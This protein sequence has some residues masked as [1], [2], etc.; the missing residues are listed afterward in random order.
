MTN[1]PEIT[2]V[3]AD[4]PNCASMLIGTILQWHSHGM[5]TIQHLLDVPE[6]TETVIVIEGTEHPM[7]LSGEMRKAFIA[8]VV[9]ASSAFVELPFVPTSK[10]DSTDEQQANTLQ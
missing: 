2:F 10:E 7:T 1:E 4:D 8:G 6:N 9:A 5:D 3:S